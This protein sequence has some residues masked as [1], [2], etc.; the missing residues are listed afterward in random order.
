MKK[1]FTSVIVLAFSLSLSAEEVKLVTLGL[2][3]PGIDEPQLTG[4]GISPDGKYICGAVEYG[5]GGFVTDLVNGVT[6]FEMT[7]DSAFDH[8]NNKGVAIGYLGDM[9][10]TYSWNGEFSELAV[11]DGNYKYVLG[12]DLTDDGS[13]LV[14]S[15]VGNNYVTYA[16]YSENGGE[17]KKLPEAPVEVI[18]AYGDSSS[19][20][21][22]SGDGKYIIGHAGSFGPIILWTRGDDGSYEVDALYTHFCASNEAELEE[23][24]LVKLE[25]QAISNNGKYILCSASR[26]TSGDD[27][28]FSQVFPAVYNTETCE[29]KLYDEPQAIDEVGFGLSGSAIADDGTF[30]GIIG[31]MALYNCAGTFI[32]KAGETQAQSLMEAYPEYA[33]KFEFADMTGMSVPTGISADGRYILGYA[34]YAEDYYDDESP[35]YFV[36]YIIDNG[37]AGSAV[38]T[39]GVSS[40]SEMIYSLDGSRL[41]E[42]KRG[43]NIIRMSDGS[44]RKVI[45]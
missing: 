20:K 34:F 7:D 16:A 17:W 41:S 13:V 36:T 3:V 33:A 19:A 25:P 45:K 35:A 22:I 39:L 28:M 5:E 29:L 6:N 32:M 23:K 21:C 4:L 24:P 14:G 40:S 8:V 43:I 42:L 44:V 26:Y 10:V 11:P 37:G 30:I 12:E 15:L 38:E 2:G 9:G 18:D 1:T 27:G 31:T